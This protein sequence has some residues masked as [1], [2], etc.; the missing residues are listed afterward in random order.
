MIVQV[1]D[2]FEARFWKYFQ[3]ELEANLLVNGPEIKLENMYVDDT[4]QWFYE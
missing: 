2:L 4:S 1:Q 3:L